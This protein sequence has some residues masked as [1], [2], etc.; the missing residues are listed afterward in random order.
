VETGANVG[1]TLAYVAKRYPS[2]KCISCE[3]DSE[4]YVE[5]VRNASLANVSLFKESSQNFLERLRNQYADIF[6]DNALY[7]LDAHGYGF[8]WPLKEEVSFITNHCRKGF[9]LIDD[10]KVPGLDCFG[11]DKYED[12]ECSFEYISAS[13]NP[14]LSYDLY[15]P[16]YTDITSKHH[17]LRGWCLLSFGH[18]DVLQL[19]GSLRN[20]IACQ[21]SLNFK[22]KK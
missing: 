5:A 21:K 19:P 4:A 17:P 3:P 13:L 12:Q 18:E 14:A 8:K 16:S 9:I 6:Q 2:I 10:F 7:W 20:K 15:Y 22:N 1:T 11:Y